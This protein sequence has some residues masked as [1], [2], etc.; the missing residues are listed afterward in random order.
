M[1][2][3]RGKQDKE[4]QKYSKRERNCEAYK[5][6]KFLKGKTSKILFA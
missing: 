4:G 5:K 3:E 1:K 2:N 6:D